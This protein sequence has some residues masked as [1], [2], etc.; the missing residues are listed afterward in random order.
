MVEATNPN[1]P[2]WALPAHGEG[3]AEA[4]SQA[5]LQRASVVCGIA[6]VVLT[7]AVCAELESL[8][9]WDE[10]WSSRAYSFMLDHPWCEALAQAATW[11][12][13]GLVVTVLTALVVLACAKA[14]QS[15]LAWWLAVTV[16]G[17]ALVNSL[18]KTGLEQA[19]PSTAGVH[20]SA[21]GFA[22]PSGHAQAATV[23]YVAIVLVVVGQTYQPRRWLRRVSATAV[24]LLVAAVGL[25]RVFL[26][27]HWPSDVLGG[28]LLGSTW[29]TASTVFLLRW[30][31]RPQGQNCRGD[32]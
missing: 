3:V 18:V 19:R 4:P 12:A 28:W 5:T 21:N 1:T 16:A 15:A 26:G 27:A 2:R 20:T 11:T 6:F 31:R 25:S 9:A 13:N 7:A 10:E 17:S 22:F 32:L 14:H 29:I 23:T 30:R 24:M 8:L